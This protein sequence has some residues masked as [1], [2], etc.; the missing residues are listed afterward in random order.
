MGEGSTAEL[1]VQGAIEGDG[2]KEGVKVEYAT[3]RTQEA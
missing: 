2:G 1:S 3:G